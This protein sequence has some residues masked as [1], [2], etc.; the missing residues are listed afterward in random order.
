ME[1]PGR[2]VLQHPQLPHDRVDDVVDPPEQHDRCGPGVGVHRGHDPA[3]VV[4]DELEPELDRL[5][6]DDEV[7]L[8]GMRRL[9]AQALQVEQLGDP[10]V[11]GVVD[12]GVVHGSIMAPDGLRHGQG[13]ARPG[14]S[15][16]S[17]RL[18]PWRA[19]TDGSTHDLLPGEKGPQDACG[20]FGVWAPGEEVAKLTYFGLYA[21]QHRGQESAG[22]RRL[23]TAAGSSST[24]TWAWSS[25]VFDESHLASLLGHLAVGH[26]RYSTTGSSVWE[27]AQ[28][29]FRSTATGVDRAG[30]QRQ[31]D[32]HPRARPARS[33][34]WPRPRR[35]AR[36]GGAPRDALDQRHRPASPPCSPSHPDLSLEAAALEVLPDAARRLLAGVDG[37]DHALRR[38]R[39]AGRSGRWCSAGSSAAGW[40]RARPRRWTSSARRSSARSS[41]AS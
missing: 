15:E 18:V 19:A 3:Q 16:V 24:R 34:S 26:C 12:L 25:Q 35:A 28:P 5:V 29:T 4:E 9:A 31:P 17:R 13:S 6:G 11:A 37:R 14:A 8:L 38:A 40:S 7:Q 10:Q 22:H 32:Q 36:C 21:L 39:P 23:A 30:P 20:V 41:R 1:G 27:N 2:H 33:T